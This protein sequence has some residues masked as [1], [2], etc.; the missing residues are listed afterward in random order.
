THVRSSSSI[1]RLRFIQSHTD[2]CIFGVFQISV[3]HH[4]VHVIKVTCAPACVYSQ[5]IFVGRVGQNK[6]H[7]EQHRRNYDEWHQN[8]D[9][10]LFSFIH[11]SRCCGIKHSC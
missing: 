8:D 2:I 1:I 9:H 7:K 4:Q 6:H 3:F 11:R 10:K 5:Y